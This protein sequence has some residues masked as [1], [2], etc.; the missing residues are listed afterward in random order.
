MTLP[1]LLI[2]AGSLLVYSGWK[3]YSP[4]DLMLGKIGPAKPG[5]G[6]A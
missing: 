4:V 6:P 3:G 1:V 2:L 5:A